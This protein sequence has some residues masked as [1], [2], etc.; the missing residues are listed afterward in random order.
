MMWLWVS[1][2]AVKVNFEYTM[3]TVEKDQFAFVLDDVID[4]WEHLYTPLPPTHKEK[5]FY[6]YIG[7]FT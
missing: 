5:Q 6:N 2:N 3:L 7:T 1:Y 4:H